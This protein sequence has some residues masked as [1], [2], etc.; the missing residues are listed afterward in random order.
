M[1]V[2]IDLVKQKIMSYELE[3]ALKLIADNVGN[4]EYEEQIV[5]LSQRFYRATKEQ[6]KGTMSDDDF[7]TEMNKITLSMT[8]LLKQ[9]K[10][11]FISKEMV[12]DT[13]LHFF[14]SP[15]EKL[16]EYK[17]RVYSEN[18]KNDTTCAVGWELRARFPITSFPISVGIKWRFQRPNNEFSAE[19]SGDLKIPIGWNSYWFSRTWG[20]KEPNKWT[21]GTYS[22]EITIADE[23]TIKSSFTI[24]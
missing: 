23:Q 21:K 18:F 6:S 16:P 7:E 19:Y 10:S 14:E 2:N 15:F 17:D 5:L 24:V 20:Y 12:F 1:R 9:L 8:N 4:T 22:L 3:E 11:D 13:K